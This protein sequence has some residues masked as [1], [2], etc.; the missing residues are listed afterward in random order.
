[1]I[2]V[3]WS[4]Q[5]A[6][7]QPI[8]GNTHLPE[9]N[10]RGGLLIC[11]GFKGYKDYG[12]FPEL[13]RC[14]AQHQ[15]MAYR[16]NFSHSGMTNNVETFERPDLFERDT[17]S[18]QVYDV[19]A[20]MRAIAS[21]VL[22][23]AGLPLILFGHSRGGI[24]A[25]LVASRNGSRVAGLVAAAAPHQGDALDKQQKRLLREQGFLASPS[26]RTGQNLRVGREWLEE[27]EAAPSN[28]DPLIAIR[29]IACPIMLIHG[30]ADH[31][32]PLASVQLLAQ[33]ADE[34]ARIVVIDDASH[35]F[36]APNPLPTDAAVPSNTQQLIDVACEFAL[37][38]CPPN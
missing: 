15:L 9:A 18:K 11:H 17:W 1:M 6:N 28:S 13:A 4:I 36:D 24:T 5:G 25:S 35:T 29:S 33:A 21:G 8:F 19:N 37:Q 22:P 23:G 38:C 26:S 7:D 27:I 30:S 20:V 3:A 34:R 10:P 32:V 31:T 2:D 12:F 14:A 16:F